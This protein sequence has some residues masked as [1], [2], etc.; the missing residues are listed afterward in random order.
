MVSSPDLAVDDRWPEWAPL[1][2]AELGVGAMLC[3]RLYTTRDTLGGL[4][5]YSRTINGFD[6]DDVNT[7]TFLAANIAV[8]LAESQHAEQMVSAAPNRTVIGEAMG[9]LMERFDLDEDRAFA[10]LR[11]VS[12]AQNV[13]LFKIAEEL[14]RTRKT[15][16]GE[17]VALDPVDIPQESS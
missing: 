5:L 8:A 9:I 15:P 10:V 13:K 12:Q 11:R 4:N 1:V 6:D 7:A 17:G 14:V 16:G 3:L 2:S